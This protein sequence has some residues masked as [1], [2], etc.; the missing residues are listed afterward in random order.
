M[1]RLERIYLWIATVMLGIF[2][3]AIIYST[4]VLSI[5]IPSDKGQ[6]IVKPRESLVQSVFKTPPF[7]HPGLYKIG[8][9]EYELVIVAQAWAFNP[10]NIEIPINSLVRIKATSLDLQHGFYIAATPVNIMLIPG[11]IS[12]TSYKF[13]KAGSYR[14]ICNEYC[15]MLHH[16]M[17]GIILVK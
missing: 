11:E 13:K 16:A 12:V 1:D 2:M 4:L 8:E 7:D 6:I 17:T 10:T 9:K 15:G 3:L 14:I 5:Q